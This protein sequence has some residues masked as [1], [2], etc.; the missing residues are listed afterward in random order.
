MEL[1]ILPDTIF[2]GPRDLETLILTG[3]LFKEL[4]KALS[5]SKNLKRLVLDDNP[6]GNLEGQK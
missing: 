4:P 2:H 3:N 6:I 1:E 5:Y